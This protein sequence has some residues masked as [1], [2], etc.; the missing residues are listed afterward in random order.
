MNV[1]MDSDVQL[2]AEFMQNNV[3]AS[4]LLSVATGLAA[5]APLL[6]GQFAAAD[7]TPPLSLQAE[8]ISGPQTRST[9]SELT[10]G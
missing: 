7:V 2:V 6:W 3:P 10:P 5:C 8:P 4:R 1:T 9:S